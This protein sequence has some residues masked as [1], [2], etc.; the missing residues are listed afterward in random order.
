MPNCAEQEGD[1]DDCERMRGVQTW[2]TRSKRK[3]GQTI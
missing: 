2:E 3:G 1:Q